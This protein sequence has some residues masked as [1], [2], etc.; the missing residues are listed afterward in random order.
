[1]ID[2]IASSYP[3]HAMASRFGR[4]GSRSRIVLMSVEH[5]R[6]KIVAS[7]G[8]LLVIDV[9]GEELWPLTHHDA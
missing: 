2:L 9:I 6:D 3:V 5:W 4:H 1:M 8:T 7:L